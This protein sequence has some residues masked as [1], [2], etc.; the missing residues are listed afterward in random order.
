VLPLRH[1]GV[2][3]QERT[4]NL[5]DVANCIRVLEPHSANAATTAESAST[6]PAPHKLAAKAPLV[7]LP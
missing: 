1:R 3:R 6:K 4:E 2:V 5:A 7:F